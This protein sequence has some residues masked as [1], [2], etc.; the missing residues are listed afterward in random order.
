MRAALASAVPPARKTP[1]RRSPKLDAAKPLIDAML[2]ADLTAWR[3]QQAL[4]YIVWV[5]KGDGVGSL[6][7]MR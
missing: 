3:K 6:P 1:V 7:A 5:T 2:R 4:R